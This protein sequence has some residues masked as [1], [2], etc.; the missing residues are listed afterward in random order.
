MI[1]DSGSRTEF[2]SGAVRDVQ[3]GKGRCE[4]LPLDI[5]DKL[6]G[7]QESNNLVFSHI[8][9]FM[10]TGNIEILYEAAK[11]LATDIFQNIETAI[12]E[13]SIHY[14]EGAEKYEANNWRKGINISRYIDSGLRHYIKH[15]RGDN[16]ERHD[17]AALW[18]I[19]SA[20]WTIE[21]KPEMDDV[22]HAGYRGE[23]AKQTNVADVLKDIGE[24][25]RCYN[26]K[27]LIGVEPPKHKSTPEPRRLS[28]EDLTLMKGQMVYFVP[29]MDDEEPRWMQVVYDFVNESHVKRWALYINT[30]N[31]IFLTGIESTGMVFDRKCNPELAAYDLEHMDGQKVWVDWIKNVGL[32]SGEYLVNC[33]MKRISRINRLGFLTF[34]NVSTLDE[35]GF[36]VYRY[37]K[38]ND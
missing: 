33:G 1:K 7:A 23:C 18:N 19:V 35:L 31:F 29:Y 16:D 28:T 34:D 14:E 21:N 10:R 9:V 3:K 30:D 15:L 37:E 24:A 13:L 32:E 38:T 6:L 22:D 20:I 26:S 12:L 5:V 25:M 2:D 36:K 27:P 8:D 11:E 4:L 17:R